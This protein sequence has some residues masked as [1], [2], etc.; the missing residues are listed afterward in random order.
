MHPSLFQVFYTYYKFHTFTFKPSLFQAFYTSTLPAVLDSLHAIN[1]E[2]ATSWQQVIYDFWWMVNHHWWCIYMVVVVPSPCYQ[3]VIWWC[4]VWISYAMFV[5]VIV[6]SKSSVIG[7]AKRSWSS[8][9]VWA[10]TAIMAIVLDFNTLKILF[11]HKST[12]GNIQVWTPA[13]VIKTWFRNQSLQNL[14]IQGLDS[15][16]D[17]QKRKL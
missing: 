15:G 11:A 17:C 3:S 6:K 12:P 10:P 5:D 2:R 4:F 1:I 14:Q 9:P 8:R 13:F 16:L 7:N